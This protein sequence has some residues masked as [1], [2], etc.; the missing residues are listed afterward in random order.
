MTEIPEHLLKRS[1]E[2]RAA[3]GGESAEG[4]PA[5]SESAAAPAPVAAAT[6]ARAAAAAP[7]AAAEPPAPP[8]P[9]PDPPYIQAA[10]RRRRI[11]YWAMPVLAALPLWGYV[12]GGSPRSDLGCRAVAGRV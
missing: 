7:P 11:P 10:K 8:P 1:R 12:Y 2:R 5:E 3:L 6:P 4:A 9:K